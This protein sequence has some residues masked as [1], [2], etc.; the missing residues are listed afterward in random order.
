MAAPHCVAFGGF[1]VD[2]AISEALLGFVG[3]GALADA[4]NYQKLLRGLPTS[5][6][7]VVK[8]GYPKRCPATLNRNQSQPALVPIALQGLVNSRWSGRVAQ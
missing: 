6:P 3:S 7:S 8:L 1:R 5:L 4:R 2:D